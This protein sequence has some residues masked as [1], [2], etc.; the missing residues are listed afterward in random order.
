MFG[1]K[2]EEWTD[3]SAWSEIR[4]ITLRAHAATAEEVA[5]GIEARGYLEA[6]MRYLEVKVQQL[7]EEVSASTTIETLCPHCDCNVRFV[8]GGAT[9][10]AEGL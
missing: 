8:I 3:E 4:R 2:Q 6:R 1:K 10:E 9:S 5:E 7:T